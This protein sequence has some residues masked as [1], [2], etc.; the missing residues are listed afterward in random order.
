[1][2]IKRKYLRRGPLWWGGSRLIYRREVW[3]IIRD[4]GIATT[5]G[6]RRETFGN[7]GSDHYFLNLLAYAKDHATANNFALA[8]KIKRRLLRD[9]DAP[10]N[11]DYSSFY[12]RRYGHRYRVQ[13]IAGTHGTGPHLHVGIRRV[14]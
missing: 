12:I 6:K 8:N 2:A 10:A 4:A 7:P 13:I 11:V 9:P 5:S 1:M 3:P 14:R